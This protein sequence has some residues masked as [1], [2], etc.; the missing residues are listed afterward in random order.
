MEAQKANHAGGQVQIITLWSIYP[1]KNC[2]EQITLLVT[3]LVCQVVI[4]V[5]PN[6]SVIVC[7]LELLMKKTNSMGK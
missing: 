3:P 6:T 4:T 5:L 7:D 1:V 2:G